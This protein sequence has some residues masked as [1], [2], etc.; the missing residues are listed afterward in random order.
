[1]TL[2]GGAWQIKR[3]SA[4]RAIPFFIATRRDAIS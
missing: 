2:Q 3:E 1:M 4:L